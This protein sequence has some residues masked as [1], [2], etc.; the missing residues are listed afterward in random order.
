MNEE[1]ADGAGFVPLRS[2]PRAGTRSDGRL[3]HDVL[4]GQRDR[5]SFQRI[6]RRQ[7]AVADRRH[8]SRGARSRPIPLEPPAPRQGIQRMHPQLHPQQQGI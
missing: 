5:P 8:F 1:C 2:D 3:Q 7:F 6:P 4:R